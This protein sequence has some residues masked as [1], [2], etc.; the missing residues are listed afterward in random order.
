MTDEASTIDD[1]RHR[2]RI[3]LPSG[4]I[5]RGAQSRE[6][7]DLTKFDRLIRKH[8][9]RYAFALGSFDDAYQVAFEGLCEARDKWEPTRGPF[10][11]IAAYYVLNSLNVEVEQQQKRDGVPTHERLLGRK[12]SRHREA[13]GMKVAH[14]PRYKVVSATVV[15]ESGQ[16]LD[17]F[18][19][20][21]DDAPSPEDIVI[22]AEQA[23]ADRARVAAALD[24]LGDL[25]D[26]LRRVLAETNMQRGGPKNIR[27]ALGR[28]REK[29]PGSHARFMRAI[30]KRPRA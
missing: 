7:L 10:E 23:G 28:I 30:G 27:A 9:R 22:A 20:V 14:D 12:S 4:Q 26:D 24:A 11:T 25:G 2:P 18:E 5:L 15:S 16:E 19:T 13:A 8:A 3:V 21:A 29:H 1:A 6:E 17:L